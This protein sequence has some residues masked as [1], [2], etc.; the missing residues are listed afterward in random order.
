MRLSIRGRLALICSCYDIM[1]SKGLLGKV[2]WLWICNCHFIKECRRRCSIIGWFME[3][4]C[5]QCREVFRISTINYPDKTTSDDGPIIPRKKHTV[6]FLFAFWSH[7]PAHA[8]SICKCLYTCFCVCLNK[9]PITVSWRM[10]PQQLAR[11]CEREGPG[12]WVNTKTAQAKE[13]ILPP[14]PKPQRPCII[15]KGRQA[16]H[17]SMGAGKSKEEGRDSGCV[18]RAVFGWVRE[19]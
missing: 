18:R 2:S 17:L 16:V 19:W 5:F 8:H 15:H 11:C 7:A 3:R 13:L 1:F 9:L 4:R 6:C 10:S 14:H 12:R